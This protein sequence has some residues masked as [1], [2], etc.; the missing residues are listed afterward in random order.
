MTLHFADEIDQVLDLAVSTRLPSLG[1]NC[2]TNHVACSQYIKLQIF[3]G[4]Q[5]HLGGWGSQIFL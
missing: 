5:G 2:C 4:F 1:D 3:M